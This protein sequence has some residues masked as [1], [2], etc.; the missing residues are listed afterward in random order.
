MNITSNDLLPEVGLSLLQSEQNRQVQSAGSHRYSY[1]PPR[2]QRVSLN[3]PAALMGGASPNNRLSSASPRGAHRLSN[4]HTSHLQQRPH[5]SFIQGKEELGFPDTTMFGNTKKLGQTT[6]A[7]PFHCFSPDCPNRDHSGHNPRPET[8]GLVD[9]VER[10]ALMRSPVQPPTGVDHSSR[11]WMILSVSG[12]TYKDRMTSNE[13]FSLGKKKKGTRRRPIMGQRKQDDGPF[14]GS[15]SFNV[16]CE[17]VPL[18]P[19]RV[20]DTSQLER[21]ILKNQELAIIKGASSKTDIN[22][23]FRALRKNQPPLKATMFKIDH[24][25][26]S[27]ASATLKKKNNLNA[28]EDARMGYPASPD[29]IGARIG[30]LKSRSE[31]SVQSHYVEEK[32][33]ADETLGKLRDKLR[34]HIPPSPVPRPLGMTSEVPPKANGPTQIGLVGKPATQ[35]MRSSESLNKHS[36]VHAPIPLTNSL[37]QQLQKRIT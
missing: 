30:A 21:L 23:G 33:L 15:M 26:I 7:L 35:K 20:A 28:L 31:N 32:S 25:Y 34:E 36:T 12:E 8:R 4:L 16:P 24:D 29:Q 5:T 37:K 11:A 27:P 17:E 13:K 2:G 9:D 19:S 1:S 14:Y 6:G 3:H 22:T 10:R 18:T